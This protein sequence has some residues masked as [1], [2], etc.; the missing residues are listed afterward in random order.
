M[1]NTPEQLDET[2]QPDFTMANHGSVIL[3]TPLSD[4]A[5]E[6]CAEHLP[7][8]AARFAQ[9]YAMEP[10]YADP[11]LHDLVEQGYLISD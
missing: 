1:A 8:D 5:G 3:L 9:A 7:E 2:E 4:A 6:W 10:R 11:I